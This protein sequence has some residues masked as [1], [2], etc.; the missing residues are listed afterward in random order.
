[1]NAAT[2]QEPGDVLDP[3]S[4]DDDEVVDPR[5]QVNLLLLPWWY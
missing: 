2:M 3:L 5:I 4:D 1:M